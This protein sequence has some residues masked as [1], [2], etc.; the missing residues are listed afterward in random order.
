LHLLLEHDSLSVDALPEY[1]VDNFLAVLGLIEEY[2]SEGTPA[3][4]LL[5]AVEHV[6]NKD[7]Q[8]VGDRNLCL[9]NRGSG[10]W[11]MD[12]CLIKF[13]LLSD[14]LD[15]DTRDQLGDF[16]PVGIIETNKIFFELRGVDDPAAPAVELPVP[17]IEVPLLGL[18]CLCQEWEDHGL[19][20]GLKLVL[21]DDKVASWCCN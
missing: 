7:A 18:T 13:L 3:K 6:I 14:L 8:I 2:D 19:V 1:L 21:G 20:E 5:E 11:L 9:W 4:L 12:D 17:S 15:S 16:T 10:P